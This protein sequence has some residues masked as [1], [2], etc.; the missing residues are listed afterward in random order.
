MAVELNQPPSEEAVKEMYR[1]LRDLCGRVCEASEIKDEVLHEV[2]KQDL[3]AYYQAQTEQG[4]WHPVLT[5]AMADYAE[6]AITTI[7]F[8][9]LALEQA[10]ALGEPTYTALIDLGREL[11]EV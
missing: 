4:F 5:E 6:D 7:A 11:F 1:R 3:L 10:H 9:R 2:R 8:Y